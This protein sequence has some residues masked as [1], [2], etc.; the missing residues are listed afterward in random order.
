MFKLPQGFTLRLCETLDKAAGDYFLIITERDVGERRV[1]HHVDRTEPS[2]T[3]P[4]FGGTCMMT[5]CFFSI[6]G[7]ALC[8]IRRPATR[9]SAAA[10]PVDLSGGKSIFPTFLLRLPLSLIS[11]LAAGYTVCSQPSPSAQP[12]NKHIE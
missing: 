7:S 4:A 10:A 2:H 3:T 8:V 5:Y 11:L 1:C 12:G 6:Y 9:R